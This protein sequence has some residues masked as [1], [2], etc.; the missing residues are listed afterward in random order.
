ASDPAAEAPRGASRTALQIRKV[1]RSLLFPEILKMVPK[2]EP[3][4][5]Q[6]GRPGVA[7]QQTATRN[8]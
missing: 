2:P 7:H 4:L 5:Q 3:E 8:R 1:E 6:R